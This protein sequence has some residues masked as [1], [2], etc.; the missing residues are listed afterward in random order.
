MKLIHYILVIFYLIT[1]SISIY[2]DNRLDI[3]IDGGFKFH[4]IQY[5]SL[6][7]IGGSF[8]YK[9]KPYMNVGFESIFGYYSR[10]YNVSLSKNYSITLGP[11]V[12]FYFFTVNKPLFDPFVHL[13]GGYSYHKSTHKDYNEQNGQTEVYIYNEIYIKPGWG[14]DIC[15]KRYFITPFIEFGTI[16]EFN[17]VKN[18]YWSGIEFTTY[19]F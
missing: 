14:V 4:S 2:A 1:F 11:D 10:S 6:Y 16:F 13:S 3:Y 7:L 5:F 8:S 17:R 15:S 12:R 18:D 19:L 9:I